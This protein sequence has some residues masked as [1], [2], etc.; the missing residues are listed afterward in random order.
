MKYIVVIKISYNKMAF[1]FASDVTAMEFA[2]RAI[3]T[4]DGNAEVR[5]EIEKGESDESI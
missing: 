5:I 4:V 3:C 1:V 2:K